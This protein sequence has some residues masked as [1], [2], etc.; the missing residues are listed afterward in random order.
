MASMVGTGPVLII[1]DDPDIRSSLA[2]LVEFEGYPSVTAPDG[3]VAL[4]ILRGTPR[5]RLILLDLMMPGMDGW[6]LHARLR[7]DPELA[8][9]PLAV[10][11]AASD[12][13]GIAQRLGVEVFAKPFD[14]EK[15]LDL[16]RRVSA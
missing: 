2:T 3:R 5:P 13:R 14:V 9:I 15:V 16:V 7:A 4:E 12:A 11:T 6:E 8:S 10:I 1:E